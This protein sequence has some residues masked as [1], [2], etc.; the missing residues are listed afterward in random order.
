M[1]PMRGPGRCDQLRTVAVRDMTESECLEAMASV[2]I[3]RVGITHQAMPHIVPVNFVML[4]RFVYFAVMSRS[5]LAA[6]TSR[7]VVAFQADSFDLDRRSGWTV[8]GVGHASGLSEASEMEPLTTLVPEPWVTGHDPEHIV[9]V[10]LEHLSGHAV[11]PI[12]LV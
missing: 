6:A 10:N 8:V 7:S 12:G 2:G 3:G 4:D 1:F 9:R 11:V 5:I